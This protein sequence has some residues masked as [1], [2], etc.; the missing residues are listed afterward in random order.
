MITV[1]VD[2]QIVVISQLLYMLRLSKSFI[3]GEIVQI[4]IVFVEIVQICIVFVRRKTLE[5]TLIQKKQPQINK[6][7]KDSE[8]REIDLFLD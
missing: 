6:L 1:D 4:C 5:G 2:E 3:L 8:S 7:M